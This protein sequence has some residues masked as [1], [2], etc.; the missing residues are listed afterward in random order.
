MVKLLVAPASFVFY[1]QPG[2]N[3]NPFLV[4]VD[5]VKIISMS[6]FNAIYRFDSFRD[7]EMSQSVS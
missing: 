3:E 1:R 5:V 4:D 6:N 2:G 7:I